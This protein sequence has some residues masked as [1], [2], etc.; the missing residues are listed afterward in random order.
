MIPPET[1]PPRARWPD[2]TEAP[3]SIPA[4]RRELGD[5][6]LSATV[7]GRLDISDYKTVIAG[8]WSGEAPPTAP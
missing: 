2:R 6:E 5:Y 8:L 3:L 7:P 1:M 4:V